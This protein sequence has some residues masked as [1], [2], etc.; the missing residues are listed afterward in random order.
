M[1]TNE[2]NALYD[3]VGAAYAAAAQAYYDAW[4]ELAAMDAAVASHL[5]RNAP[6]PGFNGEAPKVALHARYFTG[7]KALN[8][9]NVPP[10]VHTRTKA[11]LAQLLA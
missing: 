10:T 2:I 11:R 4:V 5:I 3:E 1:T 6:Q 7:A 9:P 8:G